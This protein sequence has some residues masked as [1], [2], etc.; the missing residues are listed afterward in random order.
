MA[1]HAAQ[2]VKQQRALFISSLTCRRGGNGHCWFTLLLTL[3]LRPVPRCAVPC[4]GLPP[5][6]CVAAR[7]GVH[8]SP[9]DAALPGN[10]WHEQCR[11]VGG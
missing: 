2:Y 1:E 5:L 11:R 7:L 4:C 3:P 6:Q 9:Q 10:V 8:G